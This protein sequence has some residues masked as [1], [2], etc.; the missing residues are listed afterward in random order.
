[1]N[2]CGSRATRALASVHYGRVEISK[3]TENESGPS[4]R[5]G[6]GIV[7]QSSR[8]EAGIL[9]SRSGAALSR[10]GASPQQC[11]SETRSL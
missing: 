7:R 1:M 8:A 3:K 11:D 5:D 6:A 9:P 2:F 4:R 10:Y